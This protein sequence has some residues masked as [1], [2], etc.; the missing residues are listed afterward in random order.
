MSAETTALLR[1]LV[2]I[3]SINP[4]IAPAEGTGETAIARFARTWLED[5]GVR[6]HIEEA[7]PGRPNVIAHVGSRARGP[8]G[9]PVGS[10]A[11][12][13]RHGPTLVL[14]A[15]LDT[16][17]VA[18][19]SLPPFEA[20]IDG[21]RLYGRGAYDMKGSV[22]AIMVALARLAAREAD[23]PPGRVIGALVADEEHGSLGAFDF[24]AR[25]RA[26]GC[27]VTEPS[28]EG[29]LVLAHKGFVWADIVTTGRAA[30]GGRW[31]LG[32]SAIATM[33][34]VIVELDA[35]DRTTLRARTHPLVGSASM[36]C[37]LIDGGTGLS[38]YAP[39][40]R[41][42]VERR[43]L[44]GETPAQVRQELIDIVGRVAP[45]A[46]VEI[47]FARDPSVCDAQAP[48]ACCVRDAVTEV[49]G[50]TPADA[51][52]GFWM[53]AAVFAGAGVPTVNYGPLGEGAHAAVEWVDLPSVARLADVLVASARRFLSRAGA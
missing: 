32:L 21:D 47:A 9:L 37:A 53:D 39:H 40:C 43:T 16:V 49:T 15:H 33:G 8:D 29:G 50:R 5:R 28:P 11:G 10:D 38:T 20:R 35:F 41:L 17:G 45:E 51:G 36:H 30:H 27:I 6:A 44:P 26:T 14:C 34:R 46:R 52:V 19:M 42:Q 31:D 13:D 12:A 24:V 18:D 2:G 25:H 7:A 23:L 4:L 22:A 1:A 48:V 3:P